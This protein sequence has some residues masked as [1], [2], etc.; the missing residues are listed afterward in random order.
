MFYSKHYFDMYSYYSYLK[1]W[2][3]CLFYKHFL[4][5]SLPI[6]LL[7]NFFNVD[8]PKSV[9]RRLIRFSSFALVT[10]IPFC[11]RTNN[12]RCSTLRLSSVY[13]PEGSIYIA[14]NASLTFEDNYTMTNINMK[15]Y[16]LWSL[17]YI[18]NFSVFLS[19][20]IL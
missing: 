19:E 11:R 14:N 7:E 2:S 16:T 10:V 6:E 17:S 1:L 13:K 3:F 12:S 18:H 9:S 15:L 4:N 8:A 5:I 20:N